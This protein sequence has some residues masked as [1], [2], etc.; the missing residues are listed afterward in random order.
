[1]PKTTSKLPETARALIGLIGYPAA[2][3]LIRALGGR[4]VTFSKG[5][6]AEGQAQ[7]E[8]I[9]EITG[10]EAADTL[11]EHFDGTPVYIPRCAKVL[12][13]ER[14][15]RIIEEYDAA[16]RQVSG[17]TAVAAIAERHCMTDRNVYR[18]LTATT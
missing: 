2:Q 6:R 17:R 11:S 5:K 14:D 4:T 16:T 3:E 7:Y 12:R 1:M 8:F 10:R 13:T 15:R 9:V 18:I